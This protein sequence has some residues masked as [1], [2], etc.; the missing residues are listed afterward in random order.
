MTR[1]KLT[2]VPC[3]CSIQKQKRQ[4]Q[5]L[6]G[7]APGSL[8]VCYG[9]RLGVSVEPLKVGVGVSLTGLPAAGTLLRVGLSYLAP[10]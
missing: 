10:I 5:G 7:S 2:D 1:C 6:H 4:A 9:C 3:P 8:R